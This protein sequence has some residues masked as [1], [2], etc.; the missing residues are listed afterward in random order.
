L[1]RNPNLSRIRISEVYLKGLLGIVSLGIPVENFIV[2]R[3]GLLGIN[4][5]MYLS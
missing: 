3:E 1:S 2:L 5:Y 4:V